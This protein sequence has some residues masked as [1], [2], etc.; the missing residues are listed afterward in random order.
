MPMEG[1]EVMRNKRHFINEVC[2]RKA[3]T[4]YTY[5]IIGFPIGTALMI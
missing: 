5:L 4:R 3:L 1:E 2:M